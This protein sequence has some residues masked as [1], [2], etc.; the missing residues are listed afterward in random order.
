LD[1]PPAPQEHVLLNHTRRRVLAWGVALAVF[2]LA[3][4]GAIYLAHSE[5][6]QQQGPRRIASGEQG[7]TQITQPAPG[8]AQ[9]EV[10]RGKQ[11]R[12]YRLRQSEGRMAVEEVK[13]PPRPKSWWRRL[14]GG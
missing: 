14:F 10:Q 8:V 13:P 4:F 12:T 3:A 6:W 5:R 2:G 9:I 1:V 11:T 7:R